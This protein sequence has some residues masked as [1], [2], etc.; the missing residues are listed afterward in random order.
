MRPAMESKT[1][2]HTGHE[3]CRLSW[4]QRM[5]PVPPKPMPFWH[6]QPHSWLN[7]WSALGP[8][9]LYAILCHSAMFDLQAKYMSIHFLHPKWH[10]QISPAWSTRKGTWRAKGRWPEGASAWS[11]EATCGFAI[12]AC[13]GFVRACWMLLGWCPAADH[14]VWFVYIYIY[15]IIHTLIILLNFCICMYVHT[16][17]YT[18]TY[19]Y[20]YTWI[21]PI[22]EILTPNPELIDFMVWC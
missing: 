6:F 11:G 1:W 2:K 20:I 15:I 14:D 5:V 18:H 16:H 9:P 7:S 13:C 21:F 17:T 12:A 19:I 10:P 4:R 3:G 8:R 22:L